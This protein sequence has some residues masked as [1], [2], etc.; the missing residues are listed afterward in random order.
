[1][2]LGDEK[3]VMI[4]G[5]QNKTKNPTKAAI[6]QINNIDNKNNNN[7]LKIDKRVNNK[8]WRIT[9]DGDSC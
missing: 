6:Q 7:K 1:M 3:G 2:G 5:K 9:F 4:S 8:V